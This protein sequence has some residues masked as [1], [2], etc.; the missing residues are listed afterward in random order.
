M[1]FKNSLRYIIGFTL[2][3]VFFVKSSLIY[4]IGFYLCSV[5]LY[6]SKSTLKSTL[7]LVCNIQGCKVIFDLVQNCLDPKYDQSRIFDIRPK[8]KVRFCNRNFFSSPNSE[9]ECI[10]YNLLEFSNYLF[11]TTDFPSANNKL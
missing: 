5:F 10:K 3:E 2:R 1:N 11:V 8:P 9:V 6:R 4:K 7:K